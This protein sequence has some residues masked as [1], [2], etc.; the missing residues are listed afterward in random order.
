MEPVEDKKARAGWLVQRELSRLETF[1]RPWL[2]GVLTSRFL[3]PGV[4][5]SILVELGLFFS[6]AKSGGTQ[7]LGPA[8]LLAGLLGG[9]TLWSL[10]L[11][12]R[13]QA[14]RDTLLR[15][16]VGE[17][18]TDRSFERIDLT[19]TPLT[20]I[21]ATDSS[22]RNTRLMGVDLSGAVLSGSCFAGAMAGY[23][24]FS[25]SHMVMTQS[26]HGEFAYATFAEAD[27]SSADFTFADLRNADLSGADLR[28]ADFSGSDLRGADLRRATILGARFE[29]A[30]SSGTTLWPDSFLSESNRAVRGL[31]QVAESGQIVDLRSNKQ[32]LGGVAAVVMLVFGLSMG[33]AFTGESRPTVDTPGGSTEVMGRTY[34][35]ISYLVTGTAS[36]VDIRMTNESNGV[37]QFSVVPPFDR[38]LSVP[39]GYTVDLVV[40]VV[41]NGSASCI[42]EDSSGV[43]SEASVQ[44]PGAQAVCTATTR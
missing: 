36:I 31:D 11:V 12:D 34:E 32:V 30:I 23:A 15:L 10:A 28:N 29:G 26:S 40:E 4:F 9:L 3:A 7:V 24:D 27:L 19:G 25:G 20:G 8:L 42:I 37:E 6:I 16:A 14:D 5:I 44:G 22:F 18:M 17:P 21:D 41:G 13:Q 1:G 2:E 33:K 35:R 43:L 39:S 38:L